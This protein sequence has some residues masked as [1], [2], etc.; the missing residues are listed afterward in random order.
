MDGKK[1]KIRNIIVVFFFLVSFVLIGFGVYLNILATP[2]NIT[3]T[4]IDKASYL[5]KN[6]LDSDGGFSLGDNFTLESDID[7]NMESEYYVAQSK[8]DSSALQILNLLN[9]IS[10][11]ETKVTIKQN[12]KE[13]KASFE[14]AG[15][16]QEEK[17][18]NMKYLVDNATE[19]YFVE[20]FLDSYVNN[21]S[22]N[23]F[24]SF[25][26]N[27]STKENIEYL[28][29]FI[30]ES[31]KNN[32]KDEYFKKSVEKVSSLGRK[33]EANL[34]SM[35]IDDK[36]YK[37]ILKGVLA[38]LKKDEKANK[39]LTSIDEDFAKTKI[40]ENKTYLKKDE[41]YT[42]NIYT[43]KLLNKHL[44]TEIIYTSG[45]SR[46]TLS[47]EGNDTE[48]NIYFISD[49]KLI[50]TVTCKFSDNKYEFKI[51]DSG[52]KEY[53]V[54]KVEFNSKSKSISFTINGEE[55]K[56]DLI[57]VS[58]YVGAK[59]KNKYTTEQ[60]LTFKVTENSISKFNGDVV[61]VTKAS[62]DAVINEDVSNAVLKSTVTEEQQA[63]LDNKLT[64]VLERL[65]R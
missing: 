8:V 22:C 25:D 64:N 58:K 51:K 45:T 26:T 7:F 40:K 27:N 44:K 65:T 36:V 53:G 63:L 42:I 55:M 20:G 31:V 13:K 3:G 35:S 41:N 34:V 61:V 18:I 46:Q 54:L 39:I 32:L 33:E 49:G 2:R 17:L 10:N 57:Y 6:Y 14:L 47:Y 24:E 59:A 60:K 16:I 50:Y 30:L 19:Y 15:K 4:A 56:A 48:G 23:Y 12:A 52:D 37:E 5:F 29:T 28:Y 9:N 43:T 11:L 1:N 38:D 21:G 62:N